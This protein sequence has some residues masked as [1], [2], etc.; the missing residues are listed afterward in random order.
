MTDW[1]AD[2]KEIRRRAE[3]GELTI[4]EAS[5]VISLIWYYIKF[6]ANRKDT[7]EYSKLEHVY[8]IDTCIEV[9]KIMHTPERGAFLIGWTNTIPTEMKAMEVYK[10]SH[11]DKFEN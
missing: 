7:P 10:K 2:I 1:K 4:K 9:Y 3:S 8:A 11:K 5:D 6:H